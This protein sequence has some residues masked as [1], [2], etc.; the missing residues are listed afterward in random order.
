MPKVSNK[1]IYAQDPSLDMEDYLLGTNNNTTNKKTQTYSLGSIFSLFYNFLGYN[2]FLFTTD[3][4][5]YPIASPGCFFAFDEHDE[6]TND[7]QQARK[8]TFSSNDTYN[9]NVTEYLQM[10]VDSDKFLFKL[11]NLEDKNNFIFLK[12]SNFTLSNTLTSFD[13]NIEIQYGL[14]NGNFVNYKKYLLLLEFDANTFD[15]ADYDLTD[16]TNT[17]ANPFITEQELTNALSLLPDPISNHSELN[18]DDGTNPH[19]TTKSDVGLSNVDNTSDVYKPISIATQQALDEI[20]STLNPDRIISLGTENIVGNE[21]T[22]E[23]YTWQL[24]GVQV[25]NIGNPS[26]IVIPSATIGFKRKD[27]SVFTDSGTIER[28]AGTETDGEVVTSPDVPEGT[29]YYKSYDIDGDTIEVDPEPP[30]ID[31]AIYKKKIENTRYKSTLS[32]ENVIIPFQAAG[33]SHYSVTNATLVSVAGF[34]TAGLTTPMYEGQD[35]IFENQTGHDITLKDSFGVD[36][37]FVIGADLIVPNGGKLWMRVRNRE[38]ELIMK[39]WV[40]IDLSTKADLVGGKVPASQLPSYVDDVLEFV[41]LASFPVT[42]ETGKIYLAL[43][44]N[45]T[46]RWSGSAYVQIGDETTLSIQTKRPLKTVNNESLE[47]S[48]N[49]DVAILESIDLHKNENYTINYNLSDGSVIPL[50]L[51]QSHRHIQTTNSNKWLINHNLG[52]KPS[53]TLVDIDGTEIHGDIEYNTNNEL[54]VT[55]SEQV[56]G[57]AYL[58]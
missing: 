21:Y 54:T 15:P 17:S 23:D 18:L 13:V 42:G 5:T 41:D 39:S 38:F 56:K 46:Y 33:Q 34:T 51:S 35:V 29:L 44:T 30:A 14:S 3:T 52:Y 53:V 11:I 20:N 8:L 49:V 43:D 48:G 2:A 4:D 31:G 58:N 22:Y 1:D 45:S 47:G 57:E 26:V 36:T 55:F 50:E 24:G 10:L 40:D 25:N 37:S 12:P 28:V 7:F 27:I 9:F 6:I 19:G 32:G 16:F